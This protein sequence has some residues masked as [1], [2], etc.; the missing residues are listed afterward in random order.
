MRGIIGPPNHHQEIITDA[1]HLTI[2]HT[3]LEVLTHRSKS[4]TNISTRWWV[5]IS[6]RIQRCILSI[7][8][9]LVPTRATLG[10]KTLNS[11]AKT[12]ANPVV[13]M[14][15]THLVMHRTSNRT[16]RSQLLRHRLGRKIITSVPLKAHEEI[17]NQI[18]VTRIRTKT[19]MLIVKDWCQKVVLLD[20][21]VHKS[22][23]S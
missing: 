21:K 12:Q 9:S 11:V 23:P 17:A 8:I 20:R 10:T 18:L 5:K 13:Y 1:I 4:M 19:F 2:V 16:R 15:H 6:H 3:A 22:H 7:Q 14:H